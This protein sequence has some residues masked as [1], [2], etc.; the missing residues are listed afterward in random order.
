MSAINTTGRSLTS[1]QP[2]ADHQEAYITPGLVPDLRR[3]R[4][5]CRDIGIG[6]KC[7]DEFAGERLLVHDLLYGGLGYDMT[8]R[9]VQPVQ[10]LGCVPVDQRIE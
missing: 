3:H 6:V 4:A 5:Q 2:S 9:R 7:A 10:F 8:L 1:S